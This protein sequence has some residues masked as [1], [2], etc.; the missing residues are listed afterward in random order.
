M[1]AYLA[2]HEKAEEWEALLGE[3]M[4]LLRDSDDFDAEVVP[5]MTYMPE[6]EIADAGG[7]K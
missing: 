5:G 6:A 7:R 3:R 4:K 2:Q 1:G